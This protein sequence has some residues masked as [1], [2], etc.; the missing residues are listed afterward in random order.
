MDSI[1]ASWQTLDGE[2][3]L[4]YMN[5]APDQ[6]TATSSPD[7][8]TVF[9]GTDQ[10]HIFEL[11]APFAGTPTLLPINN[12]SSSS[13]G[14]ISS[15]VAITPSI[16]FATL[17]LQGNG[18]VLGWLGQEWQVLGGGAL[19]NTLPLNTIVLRELDLLFATTGST[20]YVSHDLGSTW[21]TATSGLPTLPVGNEL[22]VVR[23]PEGTRCLYPA[24]YGRSLWRA[25]L[26]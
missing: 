14:A 20:V 24:T 4:T 9:V 11:D 15:I 21:E 18:Y 17:S 13:S 2:F 1:T 3:R 8:M 23:Q 6:P 12:P 26:P 19:P 5:S 10:L 22:T 7:G 16:A 25:L